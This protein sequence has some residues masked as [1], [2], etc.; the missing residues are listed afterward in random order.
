[1]TRIRA[2][3]TP[4]KRA[5]GPSLRRRERRV[6]RVEGLWG[7]LGGNE[8]GRVDEVVWAAVMRVLITQIGLVI[9]TV[10]LPAMAPAIMDSTVVSFCDARPDRRAAREKRARVHSYPGVF[11]GG[12]VSWFWNAV[13]RLGEEGGELSGDGREIKEW[14]HTYSNNIQNS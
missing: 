8:V 5:V 14:E 4:A 9:R 2:G 13:C 3:R 1:M 6:L 12:R 10:A 11:R 7:F